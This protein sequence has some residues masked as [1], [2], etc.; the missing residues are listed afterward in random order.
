[1]ANSS[2]IIIIATFDLQCP[3]VTKWLN[4]SQSYTTASC[5]RIQRG[6]SVLWLER[7][8]RHWYGHGAGYTAEENSSIF[9]LIRMC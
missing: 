1:M 5:M 8:G 2:H 7:D 3:A 6:R 4:D 9:S